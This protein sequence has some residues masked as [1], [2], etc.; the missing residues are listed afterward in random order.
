MEWVFEEDARR[1]LLSSSPGA[2]C[3]RSISS[4]RVGATARGRAPGTESPLLSL[5]VRDASRRRRPP[6][7]R[8]DCTRP[9]ARDGVSPPLAPSQGCEQETTS[10][11]M[12]GRQHEAGRQGL[13][14]PSSRSQ[15]GRRRPP[16][17][18]GDGTRPGAGVCFFL[19]PSR[20][21]SGMRAGDDVRR[22]DGATA[23]GRAP[24]CV[25]PPPLAP[26]QGCEQGTTMAVPRRYE[27]DE[28]TRSILGRADPEQGPP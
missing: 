18:R 12:T 10:A 9:G 21:Q 16:R 20:S 13:S 17:R 24:E 7:R 19:P 5:P 11:E 6:R 15:S 14:L 3:E 28:R 27:G 23:R 1:I 22:D 4:C 8:G 2:V 26:S 25:F